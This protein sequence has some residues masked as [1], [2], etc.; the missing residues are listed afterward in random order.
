MGIAMLDKMISGP[1]VWQRE[2]YPESRLPRFE[3]DENCQA[4]IKKAVRDLG[5]SPPA[6]T[7]IRP[8]RLD[9][10]SC[11]R[12]MANAR[13]ALDS[14]PGFALI[15]SLSPNSYSEEE[16]KIA[17]W[18]FGSLLGSPFRQNVKG[19]YLY[20]V[21]DMGYRISEGV[22]PSTTSEET[23]FHTDYAFG[24]PHPDYVGL[25]CV[26]PA[27]EGGLSQIVSAKTIYNHLLS[28]YPE[29]LR[30]LYSPYYFDKRGEFNLGEAETAVRPVFHFGGNQ[31]TLRYM[32]VY[33]ECGHA[34]AGRPL[35]SGQTSALNL[36]DTL[37]RTP[38]LQVEFP[39]VAGETFWINNRSVAHN[40]TAFRDDPQAGAGRHYVR[41]WLTRH[42]GAEPRA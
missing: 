23:S 30:A 25:L 3:L 26:R 9:L 28:D 8:E 6:L 27:K 33:I 14:G 39:L 38:A 18:L 1:G 21:R 42:S 13:H 17:Y 22:R 41:L 40:R 10:A 16:S 24:D 37:M 5:A 4:E 32:R 11:A 12:V 36:L 19:D 7:E 35:T 15:G 2:D 34:K 20:S 31:L 29:A